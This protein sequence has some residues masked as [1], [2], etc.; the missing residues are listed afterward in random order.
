MVETNR[1]QTNRGFRAN[2]VAC[3]MAISHW[4]L[5]TGQGTMATWTLVVPFGLVKVTA[6]LAAPAGTSIRKRSWQLW[7]LAIGMTVHP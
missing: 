7:E 4:A 5:A 1:H 3:I 2:Q 6:P